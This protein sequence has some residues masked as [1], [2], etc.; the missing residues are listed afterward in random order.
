M[1][2]TAHSGKRKP[3]PASLVGALEERFGNRFQRGEAVLGQHG[4]SESHF[5]AVLPDAVVFAHSTDDVVALV[6]LC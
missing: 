6:T 1:A 3:L 4:A 5:A 2:G